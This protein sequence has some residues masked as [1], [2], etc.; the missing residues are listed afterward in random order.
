VTSWV[1]VLLLLHSRPLSLQL[2]L[3]N[4]QHQSPPL[5]HLLVTEPVVSS[6]EISS[7][8]LYNPRKS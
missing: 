1:V 2:L 4:P 7:V 5:L 6:W 8:T 3:H